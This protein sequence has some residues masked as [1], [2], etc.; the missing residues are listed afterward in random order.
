MSHVKFFSAAM[1]AVLTA[2]LCACDDDG[3]EFEADLSAIAEIPSPVGLPTATA[4][5]ELELEERELEVELNVHGQL[6]TAVTMA[7]IHGPATSLQTAPIIF[8][9]GPAIATAVDAGLRTG[10]LVNTTFDL[11]A[12]P[13]STSGVLRVAP[14]SLITWLSD[15]RAYINIHT[16]MNPAG[17]LRGQVRRDD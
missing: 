9:F 6:T 2:S 13:I 16:Q 12:L 17:E 3:D 4:V 8:D 5:A 1:L 10:T 15:G 11:D 7:H 14:D